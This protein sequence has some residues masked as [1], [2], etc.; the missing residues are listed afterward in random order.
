MN[1]ITSL[2]VLFIVFITTSL[3]AQDNEIAWNYDD[4]TQNAEIT[5]DRDVVW[6]FDTA[7]K[8]EVVEKKVK[9]KGPFR[10]PNRN[11]E[12]GI[13]NINLGASNNFMTTFEFFKEKVTID[14]D[15]FSNGLNINTS[16]FLSP[17]FFNYNK[18]DKWG[19]GLST[20]LDV[21]GVV[22]LNGNMLAFHEANSANSDVGAGVFAEVNVHGFV[23]VQKFKIK[24]KPAV[25]YPLLYALP[26]NFSYTYENKEVDGKVD[27]YINME[28]DMRVFTPFPMDKDYDFKDILNIFGTIK[29][30]ITDI[31]ARPGLDISIGAEYP[32]SEAL[33]LTEKFSFLDFDVGIDFINIPLYRSVMEDYI[34]II[35]NLG[36]G[37]EPIDIFHGMLSG[38]SEEIDLEKYYNIIIGDPE[39]D[40]IKIT[41]PFKMIISANWRPFGSPL[42]ADSNE[43]N[44]LKREWLIFTPMLGFAINPIY[45][46]PVSFEGGIK[47]RFSFVNFFIAALN[48]GY[49]DRLWKNSLDLAVNLRLFE[50]DIGA[51][52][53]SAD[54][55][56][57]WSGG[58][59]G[60]SF[61]L[62]FGW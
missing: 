13:L 11:F 62:K 21:F 15:K 28:L 61:G 45:Y 57:S 51:S 55:L 47:T 50:I 29:D 3:F 10:I 39:K 14:I 41:R 30:T 48:I 24:V 23:T 27:T 33:G 49:Y 17:V 26:K 43:I 20:G 31:S 7:E 34:P 44:K 60:A 2:F 12:T 22:D 19:Y 38:D 25:Y 8:E 46:Q 37:D 4:K 40:K 32:L 9:E 42:K 18:K 56:K 59:F 53:Q 54:F 16:F 52:M 36:N 58:G 6:I 35:A 5:P 1:K